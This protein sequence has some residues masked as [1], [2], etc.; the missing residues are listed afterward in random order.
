MASLTVALDL[1][2]LQDPDYA[3]RGIGR[4]TLALLGHA[5]RDIWLVGLADPDLPD[6]PPEVRAAV[7]DIRANAYAARAR[8]PRADCI[9]L[10]SP[11]TH[12]PT[13]VA[14]LLGD[15][16]LLRAAV[17]HDFIPYRHAGQY[18]ADPARRL[19]YASAL[20]WL[21]RCD[22]FL[23]N[24]HGSAADLAGLLGVAQGG[25]V[26]T[27]CPLDPAFEQAR[28][29][30]R[31]G[32]GRHLL[33]VGGGD[34]RKNPEVVVRAHARSA[35]LQ[36]GAGVP[37]VVAG[38]YA[39][40]DARALRAV[41]A[42][43]GG[44][45]ELVEVPGHLPDRD[46]LSLYGQALAIVCPSRDEGF[47]IPVIEGMAAGLP[48]LASDIPAHAE[49][50]SDP[51][52]RFAA[53][54]AAAL[55]TKLERVLADARWRASILARQ[56]DVWP[57]F[58]A[59]RVADRFWDAVRRRQ[60][61]PRPAV[62]RGH[63]PRV[64][65]I[66]PVPP[67]PSGVA[68]Y[69]AC[70]CAELGRMVELHVFT[71]TDR[72]AQPRHVQS[73]RPLTALA[74]LDTSFERVVSVVGNSHFH[75]RIFDL[76]RRFGAACVAHDARMLGFY[77]SQLGLERT[78]AVAAQELGRGVTE[79]E[80]N[81]W[82]GDESTLEARFLGEIAASASPVIVHSQ[83]TASLLRRQL[84]AT[85]A[86]LP[87]AIQRPWRP[88]ELLPDRR[89]SARARLGLD[90]GELTIAT[91]GFVTR[92]KAPEVCIQALALLRD[93][94]IPARLHFVG[95]FETPASG[96]PLL[97]LVA[98]L[99]L[100]EHVRF[101]EAYVSEDMY[102]D[103]L[104]GADMAVQLRTCG[105]GSVSGA[106]SDCAA[107]GLPT[108]TNESLALA[109]GV[110]DYVRRIPDAFSPGLLAEALMLQLESGDAPAWREAARRA[111][112][113]ERGFRAYAHRMCAL[114]EIEPALLLAGQGR[115]AAA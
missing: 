1:R 9:V 40:E 88:E 74:H 87:F 114:L 62:L 47:S 34:P 3:R 95:A 16:G 68:D 106:L 77:R 109:L 108:V 71:D 110:P 18:L 26:V 39:A 98:A 5:P 76:L 32:P 22:L 51:D 20:R 69:T 37:L 4:H 35:R 80:L 50:V 97:S 23:A 101:T 86:Y 12:D 83:P 107:A 42:A 36:G 66:S 41:A 31:D 70:T 61:A 17:I 48:C 28:A 49:L 111:Y 82:L 59:S 24:S 6:P 13:F 21:R 25:V 65:L 91:F 30:T 10:L 89:A 73:V 43:E 7:A 52:C 14:R 60:P 44:R 2:C 55:R 11:M 112:T 105:Q 79:A 113:A 81:L 33:V 64:A 45:P 104:V 72:P 85:P 67:T 29:A 94:L 93:R 8:A 75:A 57:R 78:L 115:T 27:G 102:R 99:G 100:R 38:T 96:A 84:A 58:R 90:P 15:P 46:L 63:R 56:A 54:D 19:A 103:Y 53:D 92:S